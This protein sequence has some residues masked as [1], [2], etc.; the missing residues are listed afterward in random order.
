MVRD[1]FRTIRSYTS[2]EKLASVL[3]V[4]VFAFSS[5]TLFGSA[6]SARDGE[7]YVEGAVGRILVLNPLFT[8]FN[9]LDRDAAALIFSGLM[10][11]DPASGKMVEDM[12]KVTLSE[13]QTLYTFT[14]KDS[15][16]FHNGNAVTADDVYFTYH[17][18]I[19][20]EE[21]NNSVLKANFDGVMITKKDAK[22]I[23]FQ[24]DHPNSFF[25]TNL[26]VGILPKSVYEKIPVSELLLDE[27]NKRPVGSGPYKVADTYAFNSR[28]DGKLTL[29][30]FDTYH[31]GL[32]HIETIVLRTYS[33]FDRLLSNIDD[34][35]AI[36]KVSGDSV[37]KLKGTK[38]AL[39][40]YEL[41]QYKAAFFNTSRP[42]V[43]ER[44]VR[45]ALEKAINK[46]NLLKELPNKVAVDTPFMELKQDEWIYK[47]DA[48]EAQGSLFDAGYT[49][50]NPKAKGVRKNKKGVP[51]QLKLVYFTKSDKSHAD[52]E[53]V[54]TAAFLKKS[55]EAIGV[56]VTVEAHDPE[57]RSDIVSRR[58]YDVLLA[59]ESLGYD[60]DTYFFWH[61]S[62]ATANGSNLSNYR[63]YSA[64]ALIEDIRRFLD[65]TRKANRL[66]QLAKIVSGDV[67]AVFL[68]RPVYFYATDEKFKGYVFDHVAFPADRF[69]NIQLWQ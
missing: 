36:S 42:F 22:T 28:G 43:K 44:G 14:M 37:N 24:L 49:Y 2:G 38:F 19:Q 61:S 26:A 12:A 58:D 55:W 31:G 7:T 59:G 4:L 51:L 21:F 40:P 27:I 69:S 67:P 68:Y 65:E 53:N 11:Y 5:W 20:S 15:V 41:P 17:T 47:P 35:D 9:D 62:Q 57:E 64:D 8:N 60:L 63:N 48:A 18:V 45:L 52:D 25:L 3:L 13:D 56:G 23:Q 32:P 46:A 34:L 33:S 10:K 6:G 1:F 30:R 66:N 54:I 16:F 39:H 29:A 50:D